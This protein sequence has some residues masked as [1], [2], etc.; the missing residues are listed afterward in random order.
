[1]LFWEIFFEQCEKDLVRGQLHR[2]LM[3]EDFEGLRPDLTRGEMLVGEDGYKNTYCSVRKH[4]LLFLFRTLF[5][6]T[7]R[8]LTH[9]TTWPRDAST[10]KQSGNFSHK[11]TRHNFPL[12]ILSYY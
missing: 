3:D 8:C 11:A 1:M 7:F 6:T 9:A 2:R 10:K 5:A 12:H 4:I